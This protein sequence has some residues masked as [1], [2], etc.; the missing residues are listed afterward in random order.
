MPV[1]GAEKLVAAYLFDSSNTGHVWIDSRFRFGRDSYGTKARPLRYPHFEVG[2]VPVCGNQIVQNG[3]SRQGRTFQMTNIPPLPALSRSRP[4][5]P[6][7]KIQ[8]LDLQN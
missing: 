1:I 6:M 8:S 4:L 7:V 5:I 3:D 2:R